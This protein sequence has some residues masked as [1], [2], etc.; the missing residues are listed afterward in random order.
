MDWRGREELLPRFQRRNL[1]GFLGL[2]IN[3]SPVPD[4]VDDQASVRVR[5]EYPK[6]NKRMLTQ[7]V[8]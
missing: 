5:R 1:L 7:T 4:I 2:G 3:L 8:L 6:K